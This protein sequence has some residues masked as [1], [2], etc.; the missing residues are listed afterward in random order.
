MQ[1]I[2]SQGARLAG[3]GIGDAAYRAAQAIHRRRCL[4]RLLVSSYRPTEIDPQI[5][6]SMGLLG[7][8][9][10]KLASYD[11]SSTLYSIADRLYDLWASLHVEQCDI[12]H[13]W[14]H[15][16][17]YSLRRA[18]QQ[19]AITILERGGS[20]ILTQKEVL[21]EEYARFDL[22]FTPI[23]P[24]VAATS[25]REYEET[26]YIL[27][28][29]PHVQQS[30]IE[31]GFD[32]TR[33]L[34][35][36]N[37]VDTQRF[38]PGHKRD[39]LF[40]ALF[41]GQITLRKGVQYLLEAWHRLGLREA[42]LILL[43]P[44]KPD[45]FAL[46]KRYAGLNVKVLGFVADVVAA[47]QQASAFVFPSIDEGSAL[48]T[49]EAMACGLPVI[50]TWNAGSVVRDGKEGLIVP[51]RDVEALMQCIL[52]LYEDKELRGEMGLH[53]RRR[54][55]EYSWERYGEGLLGLYEGVLHAQGVRYRNGS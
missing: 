9:V 22:K 14:A 1:V 28:P 24:W 15:M 33:L 6:R 26:D 45:A 17:L 7:R 25:L 54:A 21:E 27:A 31:R 10:R 38:T 46:L 51:I 50:A 3:G 43:G 48:V 18:K 19:G 30:F 20:H 42:E 49:Y 41:V 4:K 12:F 47:Y 52:R 8:G 2:Y 39:E 29:S 40:R 37:G 32:A 53:A 34:F 23:S 44:V 5:I 11:S 16:A 36:P 13:C 55:E 35:L